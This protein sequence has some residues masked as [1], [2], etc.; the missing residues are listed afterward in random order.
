VKIGQTIVFDQTDPTN[1]Y[2]PLGF[3]YYP[4]GAHGL[5]W[6]GPEKEE[7]EAKGELLYKINGA[8][9]TCPEAG[10]TG[11]D[12]YE[13]EFQLPRE[14]WTA[15]KYTVELTVTQ[16]MADK[17]HGGVV[18]YFCHLHSKMSGKI[19]IQNADGSS[20]TKA[21]GSALAHPTPLALYPP[22]QADG[23]D[24]T[25]GTYDTASYIGSG[26]N[27]CD[28]RFVCGSL[29]T[30]FEKCMQAIDC[31]MNK[32]MRSATT[33]DNS[34]T[35]AIFMQQMIPHHVN[36]VNMARI[37]LKQVP[38]ADVKKAEMFDIMNAII[39][40]QNYEIHYFRNYLGSKGLLTG[41]A[42]PLA[43]QATTSA[44]SL[45]RGQMKVSSF[46]LLA[47]LVSQIP[48]ILIHVTTLM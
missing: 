12:C 29:D 37:V 20:V 15:K 9:T 40:S 26:A 34:D 39:N 46:I 33:A 45:S 41:G 36:A 11:L 8:A 19:I 38:E 28:Q 7:V 48:G 18:Y 13:P 16:A 14:A 1:W 44:I 5:T 30:T 31:K 21:D 4:D 24:R 2:H 17:S 22:H 43:S 23:V 25:C 35:A 6:G 47:C 3:A 32:D 42:G 10:D 27:A